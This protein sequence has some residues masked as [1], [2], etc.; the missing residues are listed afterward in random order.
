M[1]ALPHADPSIAPKDGVILLILECAM[2]AIG[3]TGAAA[4]TTNYLLNW[5][6]VGK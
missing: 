5:I 1:D 2:L 6:G 4:I 3:L